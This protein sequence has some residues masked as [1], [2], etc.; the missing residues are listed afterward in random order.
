MFVLL[1]T[2]AWMGGIGARFNTWLDNTSGIPGL[3]DV[4]TTYEVLGTGW[5]GTD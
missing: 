4:N 2:P 1:V 5:L 3:A